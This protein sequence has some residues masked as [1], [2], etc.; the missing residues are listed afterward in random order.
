VREKE[1]KV[2][3]SVRGRKLDDENTSEK[4][5]VFRN[6]EVKGN[7]QKANDEHADWGSYHT[8]KRRTELQGIT[9]KVG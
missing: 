8:E 5:N 3:F 2:L 9:E 1:W 4:T 6:G 7:T